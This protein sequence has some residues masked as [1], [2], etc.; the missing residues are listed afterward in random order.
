M[1]IASDNLYPLSICHEQSFSCLWQRMFALLFFLIRRIHPA[2]RFLDVLQ[3]CSYQ[4]NHT[5]G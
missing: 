4:L 2:Q 3:L 5:A 1:R